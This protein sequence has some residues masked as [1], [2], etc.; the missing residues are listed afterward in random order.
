MDLRMKKT[1][2]AIRNAFIELRSH[3][4]LE[5]ITIKELTEKAEISLSLIHI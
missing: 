4:P 5:K 3:K 2:A 1:L